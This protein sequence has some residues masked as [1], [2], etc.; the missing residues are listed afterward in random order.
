M[1][2]W[3]WFPCCQ[4]NKYY[5]W[6]RQLF[7][8]PSDGAHWLISSLQMLLVWRDLW[9][10]EPGFSGVCLGYFFRLKLHNIEHKNRWTVILWLTSVFVFDEVQTIWL[11]TAVFSHSATSSWTAGRNVYCISSLNINRLRTSIPSVDFPTVSQPYHQLSICLPSYIPKRYACLPTSYQP[12]YLL[13]RYTFNLPEFENLHWTENCSFLRSSA[14][15]ETLVVVPSKRDSQ[16]LSDLF[17]CLSFYKDGCRSS[18]F[19]WKWETTL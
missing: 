12:I 6:S 8:I 1:H 9:K 16:I 7:T 15:C 17:F 3:I 14:S 19:H 4:Q 5:L 13:I 11:M 18:N 2:V 10:G